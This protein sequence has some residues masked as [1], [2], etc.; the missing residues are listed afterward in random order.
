MVKLKT[1]A[2]DEPE[3]VTAAFE[4]GTPVN[5][6]PTETVAAEPIGPVGPVCPAGPTS[7]R[8]MEKSKIAALEL[9]LL[10]TLAK[11]PGTVV[12]VVP[13]A[14]VAAAPGNP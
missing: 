11:L 4:P 3:F 12:T 5:V 2:E 14:T 9:P 7:P 1:A 6:G 10:L 8:G 13:A